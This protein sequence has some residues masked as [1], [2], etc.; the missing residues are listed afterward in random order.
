MGGKAMN[1]RR[2]SNDEGVMIGQEVLAWM[3]EA[4]VIDNGEICGSI[5]RG[6]PEVGDV[7]LVVIRTEPVLG[8]AT[9]DDVLGPKWGWQKP[10]RKADPPKA[11]KSGLWRGVQVDVNQIDEGGFGAMMCFC[12]PVSSA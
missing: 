9:L 8:K 2:V 11:K 7:D 12:S 3:V 1:G 5:R 10:K 4:S 6:K